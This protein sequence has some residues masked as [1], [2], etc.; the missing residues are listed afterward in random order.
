M[1][2]WGINSMCMENMYLLPLTKDM[3]GYLAKGKVFTVGSKGG[4][5]SSK[6]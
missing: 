5:L 2:F 1:D 6:N 4:I 3:L